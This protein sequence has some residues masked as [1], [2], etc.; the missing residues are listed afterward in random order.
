MELGNVANYLYDQAVKD[1]NAKR[2]AMKIDLAKH[3]I[4][5][6]QAKPSNP[7]PIIKSSPQPPSAEERL[8]R[9]IIGLLSKSREISRAKLS[10][11]LR[12]AGYNTKDLRYEIEAALNSLIYSDFIKRR[13]VLKPGNKKGAHYY[14][15][16]KDR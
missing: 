10:S 5:P 15:K 3:S 2:E 14:I 13:H 7:D 16:L 9:Q 6:T 12:I 8:E 1:M 11:R 4:S